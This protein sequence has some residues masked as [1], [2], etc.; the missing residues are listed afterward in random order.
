MQTNPTP[1]NTGPHTVDLTCCL[2]RGNILAV[3]F[4]R[5]RPLE[6]LRLKNSARARPLERREFDRE[7]ARAR[8]S[9]LRTCNL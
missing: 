6:L 1:I 3:I 8:P 5:A 9:E 7:T 4:A 2:N